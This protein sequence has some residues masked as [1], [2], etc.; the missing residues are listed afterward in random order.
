LI[1]K[2]L[3]SQGLAAS[4]FRVEFKPEDGRF[5]ADFYHNSSVIVAARLL[6][7]LPRNECSTPDSVNVI[8]S[9]PWSPDG[10]E[11]LQS[12]LSNWYRDNFPGGKAAVA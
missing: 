9:S 11:G 5:K 8:L 7:E 1:S 12:L 6:P 4:I 2:S 3:P 10:P